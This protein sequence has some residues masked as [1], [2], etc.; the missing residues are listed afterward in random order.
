MFEFFQQKYSPLISLIIKE[1]HSVWRDKK[2][3]TVIFLPPVLQLFIFSYAATLDITNIKAGILDK[4]NTDISREFI[5][6][7]KTS[8][9]FDKI[10]YFKN[11]AELKK[12][13]DEEKVRAAVYINNDFTKKYKAKNNPE[14][15]IILD[16]R[17]TNASQIIGGYISEIASNFTPLGQIKKE[18]KISFKIRNKYNPNLS[19][20][21][22]IIS[23]LMGILPMTTVVL[24]SA[25]SLARE[26]EN[27][28]FDELIV[29]PLK[30]REII[31]G[32]V[33]IPLF[34]GMLDGIIILLISIFI[35]KIPFLGSFV[36]Y[37][38]ALGI[39]L[40]SIA[41]VGLFISAYCKTQQQSMLGVFVFM[42]P[43][44]MLSGYTSPVENITPL[45]LQKMTIINPL[46]FFLVISKG[47]IL[48]NMNFYYIFLNL[49]PIFIISFITLFG[50]GRAFK[51]KLE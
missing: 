44:M 22:F 49:L 12:A 33:S 8:R 35:F 37:L 27:G 1:F 40:I 24:L 7:I 19:Y 30:V 41:G 23:C 47:I 16:G 2:S 31:L 32:K 38:F 45:F 29:V 11:N 9:Y 21:W 43:A 10:Y 42:F 51:N 17:H 48:K 18:G 25:L 36:L 6:Q 15:L 13:I 46:R 28:T 20:H 50:A 5:R 4:D 34:F 14:I 26:K 39:F 3:R